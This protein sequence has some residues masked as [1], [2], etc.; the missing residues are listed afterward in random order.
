[1]I[2][3]THRK[4]IVTVAGE[5]LEDGRRSCG[6]LQGVETTDADRAAGL[7][8]RESCA[9]ELGAGVISEATHKHILLVVIR[10]SVQLEVR[11]KERETM[12]TLGF[13]T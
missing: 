5:R 2:L 13:H 4:I 9:H 10:A 6:I 11:W 1:M 3:F 8:G 12:F 7:Q